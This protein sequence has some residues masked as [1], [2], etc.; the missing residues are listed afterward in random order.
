MTRLTGAVDCARHNTC[1]IVTMVPSIEAVTCFRLTT[2]FFF[3][4]MVNESHS[5][6]LEGTKSAYI[7]IWVVLPI[8]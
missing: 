6:V 3:R 1:F 4:I 5:S 2:N 7:L 8:V